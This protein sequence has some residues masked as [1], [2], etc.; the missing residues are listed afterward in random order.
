MPNYIQIIKVKIHLKIKN[1][2]QLNKKNICICVL[3]N[4][5]IRQ[6]KYCINLRAQRNTKA[7]EGDFSK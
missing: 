1:I 2:S 7:Q 5:N 4:R 3:K 6:K